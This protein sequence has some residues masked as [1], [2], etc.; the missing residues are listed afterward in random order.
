MDDA[1]EY[2]RRTMEAYDAFASELAEGYDHHFETYAR[3]EAEHFLAKLS[4]GS[5]IL[6]IGCGVGSAS[7]YFAEQGYQQ[8]SADLSEE[9]VKEC[10]RRGLTNLVRMDLEALP[11]PNSCFDGIWAHTSLLHIPKHRLVNVIGSLGKTL[12]PGGALF[13]ALREGEKEGYEGQPGMERWFA[14]YQANEF[15]GYIPKAY[16]IERFSRIDRQSVTFLNYYLVKA[17]E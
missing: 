4:K 15:D 17:S 16:S 9:M 5:R 11:F 8:V 14:N 2:K 10:Q 3:L 6:D 12:K 1:T 7:R 13:I